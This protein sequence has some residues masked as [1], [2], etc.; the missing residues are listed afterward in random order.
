[1][2]TVMRCV[3][4]LFSALLLFPRAT[5]RGENVETNDESQ[6][7][8]SCLLVLS[9]MAASSCLD[10]PSRDLALNG[11]LGQPTPVGGGTSEI[12]TLEPGFWHYYE[13]FIVD[14]DDSA[15]DIFRNFLFQ[16]APNPSGP[17]TTIRY[18]LAEEGAVEVSVF[19]VE[20]RKV[21]TLVREQVPAGIHS[22]IWDGRD[23]S[24]R[25]VASGAYFC[26]LEV[27]GYAE[28]RQV[29]LSR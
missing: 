27:G 4:L 24:G 13:Q 12:F 8:T 5:L 1:M 28:T 14:V 6:T 7:Q 19:D 20:G 18:S 10:T 22:V 9:V 15:P 2:I 11:T 21:R 29:M 23:D 26:R 17:F 3:L 16:N 25:E